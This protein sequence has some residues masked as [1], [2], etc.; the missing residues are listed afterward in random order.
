MKSVTMNPSQI[1]AV[2]YAVNAQV[3]VV[4]SGICPPSVPAGW[5]HVVRISPE[6][7]VLHAWSKWEKR[8]QRLQA[9]IGNPSTQH[10]QQNIT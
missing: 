9:D 6:M 7:R 1:C 3:E 10:E 4:S 5:P 2:V 8:A